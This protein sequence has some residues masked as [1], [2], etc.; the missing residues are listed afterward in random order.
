MVI[1][2]KI[3]FPFWYRHIFYVWDKTQWLE[4]E[5][6]Q[7]SKM[8]PLTSALILEVGEEDQLLGENK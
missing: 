4:F 7:Q 3:I 2:L 5:V 8:F 6:L 1:F